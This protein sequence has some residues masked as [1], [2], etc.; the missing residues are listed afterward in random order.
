MTTFD[1]KF[2]SAL[3]KI[4]D[5]FEAAVDL[6]SDWIEKRLN[7]TLDAAKQVAENERQ[8]N[9]RT[10]EKLM[11]KQDKNIS[12][13]T[14]NFARA[15]ADSVRTQLKIDEKL[16]QT[17]ADLTCAR[18]ASHN[19]LSAAITSNTSSLKTYF[20][21]CNDVSQATA[22]V[23]IHRLEQDIRDL[24]KVDEEIMS[25]FSTISLQEELPTKSQQGPIAQQHTVPSPN[26]S[27]CVL[28]HDPAIVSTTM[29]PEVPAHL[30]ETSK[31][32]SVINETKISSESR[33]NILTNQEEGSTVLAALAQ[34]NSS[35]AQLLANG[36]PCPHKVIAKPPDIKLTPA[37]RQTRAKRCVKKVDKQRGEQQG[38][39]LAH[40][41]AT[42]TKQVEL[43][44]QQRERELRRISKRSMQSS[45]K[46]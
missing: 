43:R 14:A 44:V 30:M 10:L 35:I 12:S 21:S 2:M 16:K 29:T 8:T 34:L 27:K 22:A 33:A 23:K 11:E 24:K 38:R 28:D 4:Q 25:I 36:Q 3:K 17:T 31:P 19:Q 9:R 39:G 37:R 5:D 26:V 45:L 20:Q 18:E 1:V 42:A 7:A 15:S 13:Q 46:L 6:Q 41:R 32:E 40:A